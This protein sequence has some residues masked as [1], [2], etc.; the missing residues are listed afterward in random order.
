MKEPTPEQ[1]R[2]WL[3]QPSGE[4]FVNHLNGRVQELQDDWASGMFNSKE[5]KEETEISNSEAL[6]RVQEIGELLATL[7]ERCIDDESSEDTETEE[8]T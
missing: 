2:G 5:S 3:A 7:E 8:Q 4:W 6:G 1:L